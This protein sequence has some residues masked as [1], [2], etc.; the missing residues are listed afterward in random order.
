MDNGHDAGGVTMLEAWATPIDLSAHHGNACG[1][2]KTGDASESTYFRQFLLARDKK[3]KRRCAV[4]PGLMIRR[5]KEIADASKVRKGETKRPESTGLIYARTAPSLASHNAILEA[6][7]FIQGWHEVGEALENPSWAAGV[8]YEQKWTRTGL[9]RGRYLKSVPLGLDGQREVV[10]ETWDRSTS[11]SETLD[12]IERSLSTEVS[13]EEKW[14][15]AA[16]K[17][18]VRH[19]NST[20]EP[21]ASLTS[22]SIP[23]GSL[24][25]TLGGKL[26]ITGSFS[27]DVK[28][29]AEKS[30]EFLSRTTRKAAESLKESRTTKVEHSREFGFESKSTETLSNPNK[31]N[32]LMYDYYEV[33][34]QYE[35]TTR[36]SAVDLYLLVP[37]PTEDVTYEWV[38]RHECVLRGLVP[39]DVF[40]AG[41]EAA[42]KLETRRRMLASAPVE[43]PTDDEAEHFHERRMQKLRESITR[44][45]QKFAEIQGV[46][47]AATP[48]ASGPVSIAGGGIYTPAPGVFSPVGSVEGF[49]DVRSAYAANKIKSLDDV[50]SAT[51]DARSDLRSA[52]RSLGQPLAASESAEGA[53]SQPIRMG[54]IQAQFSIGDSV[55]I[56]L[57]GIVSPTLLAALE[58]LS[59]LFPDSN[60]V[61]SASEEQVLE[62]MAGFHERVGDL[63]WELGLV[64]T[65]TWAITLGPIALGVGGFPPLGA[66][67]IGPLVALVLV[68]EA[69]GVD[70]IADGHGIEASMR[71]MSRRYES[72]GEPIPLSPPAAPNE[73]AALA[74]QQRAQAERREREAVA[75]CEVEFERLRSHIAENFF[76]YMQAIWSKWTPDRIRGH[77]R[78]LEVE[79]GLVDL[80]FEGY[81][82]GR[83]AMRV[84]DYSLLDD[85]AE[86]EWKKVRSDLLGNPPALL[87]DKATKGEI[88]EARSKLVVSTEHLT[89]PTPG[90]IAEP[91]IGRCNGADAFIQTHR[92]LDLH[93]KALELEEAQS[94]GEQVA[95][96]AERM[97]ARIAANDL[98]DPTPG[99]SPGALNVHLQE[100]STGGGG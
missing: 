59:A 94:H 75:A 83:A 95:V 91:A 5:A 32:T 17:T 79:E 62:A 30:T 49:E 37:L 81:I 33:A 10:I 43:E 67:V 68:L 12:A 34:E 76:F 39:C 97:R 16:K 74:A 45:L 31:A 55:Y 90:V 70:L 27:S 15:L 53:S 42:K 84:A 25:V 65:A 57:V 7:R 20:I 46:V 56:A 80:N 44:V 88:E 82:E 19:T 1:V 71:K 22:V 26:G 60:A 36:P 41:F 69:L 96:E 24:P 58:D 77:L 87:S 38:L 89:L 40:L 9:V 14:S 11:R 73:A 63:A 72:V 28:R 6:A 85:D 47:F 52:I 99:E 100:R 93:A 21:G 66:L 64:E 13:G 35:V 29:E 98:S 54:Q 50:I 18:L 23:T 61:M 78:S 86:E 51:R 4:H 48:G 3:G 92:T 8:L 2:T